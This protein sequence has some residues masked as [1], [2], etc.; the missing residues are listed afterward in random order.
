MEDVHM[1]LGILS[2]LFLLG[3]Y[4]YYIRDTQKGHARPS[5]VS[6]GG[7]GFLTAIASAAQIA[8]GADWSVAVPLA[9]ALGC[10]AIA[11][12]AVRTGYIQFTTLDKTCIALGIVALLGWFITQEPI[13]AILFAILADLIVGV[14]T[15]VKS[16]KDPASETLFPWLTITI[17]T[18]FALAALTTFDAHNLLFPVYILCFDATVTILILRGKFARSQAG[19]V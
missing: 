7:W 10:T 5:V 15:L 1:I 2:V 14:P 8:K 11:L 3:G 18:T 12:V 9:S 16:Y 4:T 17:G 19:V 6:W 13:V